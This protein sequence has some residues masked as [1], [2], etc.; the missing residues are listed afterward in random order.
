MPGRTEAVKVVAACLGAVP[1]EVD[2]D[3]DAPGAARAWDP[4]A[5]TAGGRPG[6]SHEARLPRHG[7]SIA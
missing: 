7:G 4:S 5:G 6:P 1:I 3:R 2:A